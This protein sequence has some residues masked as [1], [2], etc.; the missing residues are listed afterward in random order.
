MP[1]ICYASGFSDLDAIVDYSIII[2]QLSL[3]MLSTLGFV[4]NLSIVCSF[5]M[6]FSLAV[7]GQFCGR[8]LSPLV[9]TCRLCSHQVSSM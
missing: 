7:S 3:I 6:Q 5:M 8:C 1:F 9:T 2:S 4:L